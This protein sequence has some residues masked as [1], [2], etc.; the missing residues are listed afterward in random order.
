MVHS[1]LS[2]SP[3]PALGCSGRS[4]NCRARRLCG[5]GSSRKGRPAGGDGM[6]S[7]PSVGWAPGGGGCF[8]HQRPPSPPLLPS[9]PSPQQP[10]Q[11]WGK[12]VPW[13][14]RLHTNLVPLWPQHV[15]VLSDCPVQGSKQRGPVSPRE[16]ESPGKSQ[17]L[18]VPAH[19]HPAAPSRGHR[20]GGCVE[21]GR[22]WPLG[23]PMFARPSFEVQRL[24]RC[25]ELS[26]LWPR[27]ARAQDRGSLQQCQLTGTLVSS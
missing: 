17:G 6:G 26:R 19:S 24:F 21:G 2:S 23:L 16:P 10:A 3:R 7:S 1:E 15:H 12:E 8:P 22:V 14:P 11:D 27:L 4:R 20:W 9:S 25:A 18:G 13:L 5:V